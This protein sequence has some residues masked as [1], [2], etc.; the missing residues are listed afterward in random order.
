MPG[1]GRWSWNSEWAPTTHNCHIYSPLPLSNNFSSSRRRGSWERWGSFWWMMTSKCQLGHNFRI[2]SIP[3]AQ[4]RGSPLL[5]RLTVDFYSPT[6]SESETVVQ[7]RLGMN[8]YN[9][10]FVQ[11]TTY[12]H[13]LTFGRI[14]ELPV[15]SAEELLCSVL[16]ILRCRHSIS[17]LFPFSPP[18]Q[19]SICGRFE[20]ITSY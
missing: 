6:E 12:I 15:S 14:F 11:L 3:P 18:P 17:F 10:S 9:F 19:R 20:F 2:V 4:K 7:K 13:N 1:W 5:V 16:C 8:L